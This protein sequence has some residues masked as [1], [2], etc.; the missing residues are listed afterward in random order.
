MAT[1]GSESG[2]EAIVPALGEID[3]TTTPNTAQLAV[4]LA[5]GYSVINQ[6]IAAAGYVIPVLASAALYP[7]LTALNDLY[8]AAYA[9]RARGIEPATGQK[10][11]I[12][13]TYLKDFYDRLEELVKQDLTALD[14]PLRPVA[15]LKRRRIRSMQLRRTDGYSGV[16]EGATTAYDYPSE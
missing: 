7:S 5:E 11:A 10:E 9:L 12:S 13:E 4:W 8:G 6:H 1:Y 14:V 2:V 16:F 15:S 3:T